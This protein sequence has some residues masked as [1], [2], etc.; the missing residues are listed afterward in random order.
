MV[1]EKVKEITLEIPSELL[2]T[3]P[4]VLAED[5]K[6]IQTIVAYLQ[7]TRENVR[8]AEASG[9]RISK[10]SATKTA[11]KKFDKNPLDMLLSET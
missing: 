4:L 11:P 3:D 9:K 10:G 8:H 6:G 5:E 7:A 1:K 2:E